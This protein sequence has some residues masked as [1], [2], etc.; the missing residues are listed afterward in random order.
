MTLAIRRVPKTRYGVVLRCEG[1]RFRLRP[2]RALRQVLGYWLAHYAPKHGILIHAYCAMSNHLHLVLTDT[3]GLL[4]EFMRDL[5]A[6]LAAWLNA[7]HQNR[8]VV[9]ARYRS[10]ELSSHDDLLAH[11]LYVVLNPVSAGLVPD[12]AAWPG[13][14]SLPRHCSQPDS[15]G[16]P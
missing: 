8:G 10:W 11:V 5:G 12:P 13:L 2:T 9:F 16:Q 4:G 3:L 14:T 15:F 1:R 6:K 7:E